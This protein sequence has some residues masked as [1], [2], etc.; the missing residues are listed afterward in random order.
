MPGQMG[1]L[2]RA[3]RV[4]REEMAAVE[5]TRSLV[6]PDF[7]RA[8]RLLAACRGRVVVSGVGKSGII[9]RKISATLSSVGTPSFF[10]HPADAVHGDL[11]SLADGDVLLAISNSGRTEEII[12]ILAPVRDSGAVIIAISSDPDSPLA[13]AAEI[14]LPIGRNREADC[15][16]LAP[17]ASTTAILVLGD[18]LAVCLQEVKGFRRSDYAFLHPAGELGRRL[19]LRVRDV[20]TGAGRMPAVV[21]GTGLAEALEVISAGDLGAAVVL[22]KD[23]SLAGILTDG[24]LRRFL[25]RGGAVAGAKVED[26]MNPG[27]RTIERDA[28]TETAVV[29]MEKFEI[30]SLVVV[31][32]A[33]RPVGFVHLHGVLGGKK[34][35]GT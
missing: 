27:P 12:R 7:E 9:G 17:T 26:L 19:S 8:V 1:I 14:V 5:K 23:G 32:G 30:T 18:A 13:A 16:E 15:L 24:D 29:M 6:G 21:A 35:F 31:D 4:F 22:G 34:V 2:D 3:D 25:A 20:M 10:L 33:G 11:G 28:L